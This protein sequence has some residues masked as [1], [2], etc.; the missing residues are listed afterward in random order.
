MRTSGRTFKW[1][2]SEYHGFL[3]WHEYY[4][5]AT[6]ASTTFP[7]DNNM[8]CTFRRT[9]I[10][11]MEIKG[12]QPQEWDVLLQQQISP[13]DNTRNV[14][15]LCRLLLL[16]FYCNLIVPEYCQSFKSWRSSFC[17]S[18][19]R[20]FIVLYLYFAYL[21]RFYF[22]LCTGTNSAQVQVLLQRSRNTNTSSTSW[23]WFAHDYAFL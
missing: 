22:E 3:W 15:K 13:I 18:I 17:W 6:N 7:F 14:A 4:L 20:R 21:F 1:D 8:T 19:V 16:A 9:I 12:C 5:Y 23:Y 2:W 10:A 11:T